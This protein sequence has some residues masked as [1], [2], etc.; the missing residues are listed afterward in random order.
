MHKLTKQPQVLSHSYATFEHE[1]AKLDRQCTRIAGLSH[2]VHVCVG[3]II[4]QA[5]CSR[6]GLAVGAHS[7]WFVRILMIAFAVIA[8]PISKILD[9]LL[10]AE[11]TVRLLG[12][13]EH[14][15]L[16]HKW[17]MYQQR[18]CI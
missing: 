16:S 4:P 17:F 13:S 7:A 6:H 1:N 18:I 8:Y 12:L 14:D 2:L 10:G 11:H 15:S 5:V 9:H 3:E